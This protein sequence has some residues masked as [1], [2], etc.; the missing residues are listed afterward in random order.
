MGCAKLSFIFARIG[1]K[2]TVVPKHQP[3][4]FAR[5]NMPVVLHILFRQIYVCRGSDLCF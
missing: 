2:L 5:C 3:E 4:E 1:G